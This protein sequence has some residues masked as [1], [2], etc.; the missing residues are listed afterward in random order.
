MKILPDTY[1]SMNVQKSQARRR[2]SARKALGQHYLV[3]NGTLQ[4][5]L[6]A[7]QLDPQD[8]VLEVG[9][10]RGAVTSH[11]VKRV[12]CVIAIEIDPHLAASLP[13]KLG[14]PSN[15]KVINADARDVE[16]ANVIKENTGYKLVANLPYYAANPILRRFLETDRH[17]PSL[18][19]VMVQREVARS[20]VA[21]DGRM[22]LLAVGIQLYGIPHIICDVPPEAFY[23]SPKVTSTVVRIDSRHRMAIEVENTE[24]FFD[25]VRAGFFAPRK[26][27]RNSLGMGLGISTEQVSHLLESARLDPKLR[28][29]NLSLEEWGRLYQASLHQ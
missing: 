9:P 19:V 26:Q 16:L 6:S 29:E 1:L 2:P 12:K 3:D 14:N 13:E 24:G 10:G 8:I 18:M 20:M 17:R 4:Q 27:I 25:V 11:L 28:P 7:S 15:L 5:V 23:P 22:S 21:E